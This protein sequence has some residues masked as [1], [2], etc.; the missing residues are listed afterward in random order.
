MVG[1]PPCAYP[2]RF[3]RLR[4]I[5]KKGAC[6]S[7]RKEFGTTESEESG[8][9]ST[10]DNDDLNHSKALSYVIISVISKN[11]RED[12]KREA[13]LATAALVRKPASMTGMLPSAAWAQY[14]LN[15]AHVV[16]I[17]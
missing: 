3:C 1:G 8:F 17:S 7:C 5:A 16:S 4:V 2:L 12:R 14:V 15:F 9:P 11:R 6:I 10:P 13:T